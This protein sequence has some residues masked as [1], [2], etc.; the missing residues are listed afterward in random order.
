[1]DTCPKQMLYVTILQKQMFVSTPVMGSDLKVALGDASESSMVSAGK[2]NSNTNKSSLP[3][4]TSMMSERDIIAS[5]V[6]HRVHG[7]TVFKQLAYIL[8]LWQGWFLP[9]SFP[10]SRPPSH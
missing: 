4:W 6:L 7:N 9:R 8:R 2:A 1:M 10:A 3:V 5:T